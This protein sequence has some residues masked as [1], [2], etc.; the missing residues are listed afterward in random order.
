M[1]GGERCNGEVIKLR[2]RERERACFFSS[3]ISSE[4]AV[5]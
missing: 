4:D 3:H 5:C 2:E 1:G